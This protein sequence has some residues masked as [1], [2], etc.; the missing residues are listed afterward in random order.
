MRVCKNRYNDCYQR[1]PEDSLVCQSFL[2]SWCVR[3][4]MCPI[5]GLSEEPPEDR[6]LK[7]KRGAKNARVL[8]RSS[9]IMDHVMVVPPP[10]PMVF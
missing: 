2:S 8:G 3:P 5:A 7:E 9:R 1:P 4:A 6:D 10:M